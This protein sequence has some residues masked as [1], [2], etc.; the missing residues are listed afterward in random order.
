LTNTE[1]VFLTAVI[2]ARR[3]LTTN[4]TL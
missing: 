3:L 1:P 2:I 4:K